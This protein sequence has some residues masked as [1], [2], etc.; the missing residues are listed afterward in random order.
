VRPD[1]ALKTGDG[2]TAGYLNTELQRFFS[3]AAPFAARQNPD[4]APILRQAASHWLRHTRGSHFALGQVSLAMTAEHL[5]HKDPRTTS[6]YYVPRRRPWRS[7]RL[8]L[9]AARRKLSR[10]GRRRRSSEFA[11]DAVGRRLSHVYP[12]K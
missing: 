1:R 6:K 8:D 12:K 11:A 2:V 5:R 3:Y 7:D 10:P 9:Q 4:W